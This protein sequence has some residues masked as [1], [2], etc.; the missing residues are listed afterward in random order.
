M[1]TVVEINLDMEQQMEILKKKLNKLNG[2]TGR[3][4]GGH[5]GGAHGGKKD[6]ARRQRV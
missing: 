3:G 5:H 2:V 1:K 6:A 4:G